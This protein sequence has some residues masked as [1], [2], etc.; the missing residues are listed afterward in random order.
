M[1][2]M[3]NQFHWQGK[4]AVQLNSRRIELE[5]NRIMYGSLLSIDD[6]S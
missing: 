5:E 6:M 1:K 3:R 2:S 4:S